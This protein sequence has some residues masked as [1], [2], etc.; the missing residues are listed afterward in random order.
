M[1]FESSV[2]SEGI[3]AASVRV[4]FATWFESSVNSEGIEAALTPDDAEYQFE[5]S[6][7][8][9]GIEAKALLAKAQAG[10]RAV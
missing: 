8:S 6:V 1:R 4:L 3:E 2:N 5:S 7:N 10:L 9:E